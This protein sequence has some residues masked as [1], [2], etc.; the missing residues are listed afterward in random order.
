MQV[1]RALTHLVFPPQCIAC[2]ELVSDDFALCGPC[3]RDTPFVTGPVCDQ[4]GAPVLDDGQGAGPFCCD[5]CQ[6]LARPWARGRAALL[7]AGQGRKMVLALKHGD[8]T[9]LARPAA[10]WLAR[11]AGPILLPDMIVA[12]VPLH[13]WRLFRRRYNQSALL[14]R[15]VAR[16]LGLAHCPDLLAR[17]RA[18]PSQDG[19]S[20]EGRFDNIAGAIAVPHRH[21]ARLRDRSVLLVD[22]VMTSGATLAACA[23][24]CIT[25][26]ARV[27]H[28][29]VLARVVKDG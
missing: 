11:A 16:R 3:W 14:S 8:R 7:Y 4:C 10:E 17:A 18:T 1:S 2:G 28:V 26:G 24:A 22:D 25:A 5:D 21:R 12:P 13:W 9:D 23:D 27:V 15:G 29:L 6:I 19:R 20:R